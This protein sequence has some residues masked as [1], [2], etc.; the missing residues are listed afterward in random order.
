MGALPSSDTQCIRQGWEMR[1]EDLSQRHW[2]ETCHIPHP[3]ISP[4]LSEDLSG[5]EAVRKT[6]KWGQETCILRIACSMTLS[7]H[8]LIQI[9]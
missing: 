5:L 9:Q 1:A 7:H 2:L 3:Q 6:R 8:F 4:Y